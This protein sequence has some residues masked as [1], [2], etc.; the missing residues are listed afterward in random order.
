MALKSSVPVQGQVLELNTNTPISG[1]IVVGRW[2]EALSGPGHGS[3]IC[4][5]V[6]TTTTDAEGR[7]QL[8]AWQSYAPTFIDSYKP[9]YA[10]SP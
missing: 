9:G 4:S 5:H 10:R 7:Y 8:P 1:A 2:Q 6:E 3:T